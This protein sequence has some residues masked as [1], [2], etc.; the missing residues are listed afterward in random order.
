MTFPAFSPVVHA[1]TEE[2]W[3][4]NTSLTQ[5]NITW[6]VVGNGAIPPYSNLCTRIQARYQVYE[7]WGYF[8]GDQN[9]PEYIS[10]HRV[11]RFSEIP[12]GCQQPTAEVTQSLS[13]DTECQDA[14]HGR[15]LGRPTRL[16]V[17]LVSQ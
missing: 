17:A 2:Y 9:P 7:L 10:V 12:I 4:K 1:S 13:E 6:K 5:P 15:V 16:L 3:G 8:A 11:E 14:I